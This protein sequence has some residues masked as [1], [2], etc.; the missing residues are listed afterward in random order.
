MNRTNLNFFS[1]PDCLLFLLTK[2]FKNSNYIARWI[3][4]LNFPPH[5]HN[6]AMKEKA[7]LDFDTFFS[8]RGIGRWASVLII[9]IYILCSM[10]VHYQWLR[11]CWGNNWID[12]SGYPL[13]IFS[14]HRISWKIPKCHDFHGIARSHLI[15]MRW[16]EQICQYIYMFGFN[17]QCTMYSV[18]WP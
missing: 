12:D 10:L 15:K 6:G 5:L 8:R 16:T 9:K 2:I 7:K 14:F 13:E 18:L 4:K 3:D 11:F 1:F 17:I